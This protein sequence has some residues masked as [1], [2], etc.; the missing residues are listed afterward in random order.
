MACARAAEVRELRFAGIPGGVCGRKL[1]L[2]PRLAVAGI[3]ARHQVER[4]GIGSGRV[5]VFQEIHVLSVPSNM[6]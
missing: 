6:R 2:V 3:R 5:V 1:R 4:H